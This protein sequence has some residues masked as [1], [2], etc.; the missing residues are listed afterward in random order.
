MKY[1]PAVEREHG[2]LLFA[3]QFLD[4]VLLL[5]DR[6]RAKIRLFPRGRERLVHNLD[7]DLHSRTPLKGGPQDFVAC[8]HLIDRV[9]ESLNFELTLEQNGY[10][11]VESGL[12]RSL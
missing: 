4:L 7:R 12:A 5:L 2:P 8:D 1:R 10:R 11:G 3:Q 6:Q 9:L